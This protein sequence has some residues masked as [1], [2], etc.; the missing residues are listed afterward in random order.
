[1][2]S[3]CAVVQICIPMRL[4]VLD[5]ADDDD[6]SDRHF[7]LEMTMN[8]YADS[9][10]IYHHLYH[11][12]HHIHFLTELVRMQQRIYSRLCVNRLCL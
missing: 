3:L 11:N 10:I 2:S 5:D 1:M 7:L 9:I 8:C 6:D 4:S 12:C